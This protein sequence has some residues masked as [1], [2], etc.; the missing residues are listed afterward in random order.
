[1]LK[2]HDCLSLIHIF[3]ESLPQAVIQAGAIVFK[4]VVSNNEQ[5]FYDK[6]TLED[7]FQQAQQLNYKYLNSK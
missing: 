7:W 4:S 2:L 5:C 1:M 6:R 3:M